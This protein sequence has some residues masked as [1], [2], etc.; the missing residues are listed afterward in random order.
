MIVSNMNKWVFIHNPKVAGSSIRKVLL[1]YNESRVEFWH[2][3]YCPELQRVVDMS[4]LSTEEFDVVTKGDYRGHFKFGFVRDPYARLLSALKEFST[5]NDV[6]VVSTQRARS[7]FILDKLTAVTIQYD[8]RYSHFRP[9]FM[10]FY[11]GVRRTVDFIGRFHRLDEDFRTVC[12][13]LNLHRPDELPI[14]RD[15]GHCDH[16][17]DPLLM[18]GKEALEA[19]NALYAMDRMLF[20]PY[21]EHPQVGGVPV[22]DHYNNV[23]N[24]RTPQGRFTFYGEPPNLSLG[25]K[26]GF[27]TTEIERLR[28]VVGEQ[29]YR[30]T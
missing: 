16:I 22:G 8:W 24:V 13:I 29:R 10:F 25:E 11:R 1:P 6:D 3:R 30:A 17:E 19:V 23:Q 26:V 15:R 14:E 2:Q 20:A 7:S 12:A 18:F 21:L 4:H 5:Q 27:L 28:G 9:Q